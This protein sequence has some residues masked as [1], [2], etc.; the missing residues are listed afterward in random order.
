MASLLTRSAVRAS[1]HSNSAHYNCSFPP[2]LH[3]TSNRSGD[4]DISSSRSRV[5]NSQPV[6]RRKTG[7]NYSGFHR[8]NSFSN[9]LTKLWNNRWKMVNLRRNCFTDHRLTIGVVNSFNS[10]Y[11]PSPC[12]P[13]SAWHHR[14]RGAAMAL[15][16]LLLPNQI[17]GPLCQHTSTHTTAGRCPNAWSW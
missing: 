3:S 1:S 2:F 8:W 9:L 10:L 13:L 16:S 5:G 4:L 12:L 7:E 6:N 11:Y 15:L 17:C 14:R